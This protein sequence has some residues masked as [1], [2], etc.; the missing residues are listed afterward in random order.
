MTQSKKDPISE[1]YDENGSKVAMVGS[2]GFCN[3]LAALFESNSQ[4]ASPE[5]ESFVSKTDVVK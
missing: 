2:L 3:V 4:L 5:K 1:D